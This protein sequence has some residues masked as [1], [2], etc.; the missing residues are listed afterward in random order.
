MIDKLLVEDYLLGNIFVWDVV[1][2]NF[3]EFG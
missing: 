1:F 3:I 2:I